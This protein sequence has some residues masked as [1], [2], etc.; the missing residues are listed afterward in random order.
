MGRNAG[1]VR[2]M[3][4]DEKDYIVGMAT[5]IKPGVPKARI[6]GEPED[7]PSKVRS[8][9]RSPKT[10]TASALRPTNTACKGAAAPG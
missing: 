4:L 1:G 8:F 5:T 3:K 7:D 10:A 2:G 9:C 6:E